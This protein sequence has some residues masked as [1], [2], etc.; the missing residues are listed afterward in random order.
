MSL[1]LLPTAC[2]MGSDLGFGHRLNGDLARQ[3]NE[4]QPAF[5]YWGALLFVCPLVTP[6][7]DSCNSLKGGFSEILAV[8]KF[9]RYSK[10]INAGFLNHTSS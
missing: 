8:S 2:S 4:F 7:T 9:I 10:S 6:D 3:Y 1:I 5:A